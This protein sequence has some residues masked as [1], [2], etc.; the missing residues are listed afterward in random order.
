MILYGNCL[1]E[2]T[3]GDMS[4]LWS[5]FIYLITKILKIEILDDLGASLDYKYT[6][7]NEISAFYKFLYCPYV[8][9]KIHDLI[10]FKSCYNP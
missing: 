3:N 7:W 6:I 1:K 5:S 4:I 9:V 10:V 8:T 2:D